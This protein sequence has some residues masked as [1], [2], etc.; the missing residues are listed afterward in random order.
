MN[1]RKNP[2]ALLLVGMLVL[3]A[4]GTDDG[5]SLE[6]AWVLIAATVDGT[7]LPLDDQ[8]PVTMTISGSEI[9]GRAAC[10][11]YSGAVS[12]DNGAFSA[13]EVAQT[14]MA[15]DPSVMELES[16][17]LQGLLS[18]TDSARSGDTVSLTGEGVEFTFELDPAG[19]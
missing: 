16:M 17:F 13:G 3:V 7:P 10:N 14:E 19:Q 6:G 2:I 4:C 1:N 15:C 11:S 8:Y 5:Q 18:V 12:I 9:S